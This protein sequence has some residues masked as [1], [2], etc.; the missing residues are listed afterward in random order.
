MGV[1]EDQKKIAKMEAEK[2]SGLNRVAD[3]RFRDAFGYYWNPPKK[4]TKVQLKG[5]ED[6]LKR[7]AV[8]LRRKKGR[9]PRP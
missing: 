9:G 2:K 3:R 7:E 6:D 4:R 1:K 5:V 8:R